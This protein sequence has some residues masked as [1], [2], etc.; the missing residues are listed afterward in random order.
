MSRFGYNTDIANLDFST[1]SDDEKLNYSL[2]LSLQKVQTWL[3]T[4][5][6][7]EPAAKVASFPDLA[8]KN[9][10]PN[11][12]NIQNYYL[13]DPFLNKATNVTVNQI[14][15]NTLEHNTL[16]ISEINNASGGSSP[17]LR[18]DSVSDEIILSN[19][20]TLQKGLSKSM[21]AKFKYWKEGLTGK[22]SANTGGT[23]NDTSA[24]PEASFITL[25]D[26]TSGGK[27]GF[28]DRR[29]STVKEGGDEEE[30]Y[31]KIYG[32]AS[33]YKGIDII[34]PENAEDVSKKH[35]FFKIFVGLPTYSTYSDVLK[36][37]FDSSKEERGDNI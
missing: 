33:I 25:G 16:T 10:I 12:S 21:I 36:D 20:K 30:F 28:N 22:G 17:P 19:G 5:W 35:P 1:F 18:D 32:E 34:S 24:T 8:L 13:I 29:W 11:Y 9:K 3:D 26:L 6:Y 2:K 31:N 37:K 15:T 4:P 7:E 14:L 23:F 27:N